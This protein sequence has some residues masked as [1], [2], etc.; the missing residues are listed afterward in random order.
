MDDPVKDSVVIDMEKGL[1]FFFPSVVF[2]EYGV[3]DGIDM[4][5]PGGTKGGSLIEGVMAGGVSGMGE[6]EFLRLV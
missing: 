1:G 4:D 3:G 2:K 5:M 6:I